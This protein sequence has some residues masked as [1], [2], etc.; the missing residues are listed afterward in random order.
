MDAPALPFQHWKSLL[1]PPMKNRNLVFIATS[2]DG[3]IA[4]KDG[5]IEWLHSIPNPENNDMG[6]AAFM[7]GIDALL[8]GRTTFEVVC[9]FDID[10]PFTKPVFVLSNTLQSVPEEYAGKVW[11]VNGPLKEVLNGINQK[12]YHRLYIDGGKTIQSFLQEDLVDEMTITIIPY[13]LGG[14]TPLFG[15]MDQRLSFTCTGSQLYLD[16]VVQHRFVRE[17]VIGD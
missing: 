3:Y 11:L 17:R 12:G 14:G 6:Y 13:L 1:R 15:N 10:W 9:G 5:G 7:E 16:K 8:M 2:I 4:D